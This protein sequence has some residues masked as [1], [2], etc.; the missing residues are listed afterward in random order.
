MVGLLSIVGSHVS[1]AGA[2]IATNRASLQEQSCHRSLH[3]IFSATPPTN[4]DDEDKSMPSPISNNNDPSTETPPTFQS[5]IVAL[6]AIAFMS[7]W[8]LLA[9]LRT[10]A[11]G[12]ID[13]DMFMA[14]QSILGESPM[15]GDEIV[16]LPS[17]S[18]AEQLVGAFFGPSSAQNSGFSW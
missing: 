11:H 6:S 14:L 16:E 17:L 12:Q 8:P 10:A 7:F 3:I 4:E 13:V 1:V 15:K 18:P 2:F 5:G 9:F